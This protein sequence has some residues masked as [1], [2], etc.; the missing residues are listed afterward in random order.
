MGWGSRSKTRDLPEAGGS[1][2]SYIRLGVVWMMVLVG[3]CMPYP[4]WDKHESSH[5]GIP[6]ITSAKFVAMSQCLPVQ[7]D[8]SV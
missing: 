1:G 7:F 8:V 3:V 6:T 2:R 4:K 5:L